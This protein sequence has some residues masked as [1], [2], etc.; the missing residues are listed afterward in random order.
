MCVCVCVCMCVWH[1]CV[2]VCMFMC[3]FVCLNESTCSCAADFLVT[4]PLGCS[5]GTA[6]RNPVVSLKY[7][8]CTLS[9]PSGV[10]RSSAAQRAART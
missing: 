7:A 1:V 4:V 9:Q 2:C 6:Q 5:Y 10:R 3:L 8:P